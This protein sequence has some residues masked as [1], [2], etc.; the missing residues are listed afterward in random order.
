[1]GGVGR[2]SLAALVTVVSLG[3]LATLG[4]V[5][6]NAHYGIAGLHLYWLVYLYWIGA[7]PAI[8]LLARLLLRAS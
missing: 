6:G 8:V 5:A 4:Q 7:V 1:M 2:V 3:V